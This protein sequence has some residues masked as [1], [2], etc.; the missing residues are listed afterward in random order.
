MRFQQLYFEDADEASQYSASRR[1]T[2]QS[3]VEVLRLTNS[4]N[5]EWYARTVPLV[6]ARTCSRADHASGKEAVFPLGIIRGTS[7]A[8]AVPLSLAIVA[9]SQTAPSTRDS[10]AHR[11]S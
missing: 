8:S 4:A 9:A 2:A 10:R 5:D 3:S 6:T 1:C 7:A 11:R